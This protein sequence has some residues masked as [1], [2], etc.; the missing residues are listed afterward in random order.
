MSGC[1]PHYIFT[2]IL[3]TV[4]FAACNPV[5]ADPVVV[6]FDCGRWHLERADTVK[7][8]D[9]LSLMG[10]ASLDDVEFQDGI[11]HFSV[12]VSGKS[13]Y[14]GVFFRVQSA[15]NNERFYIRPHRAGLYPDALQYTPTINGIAGWQLYSGPGFTAPIELPVNEWIPV[16]LE[17]RG[18]QARV[19]I[20]EDTEP[21]LEIPYLQNGI[22]AGGITLDGP[23][24]GTAYLSDFSYELTDD[25]V[26]DAPPPRQI[27]VGT[28]LDWELS[29][30]FDLSGIDM[31]TY[32]PE[33]NLTDIKWERV[34]CDSTGLVDIARHR[35]PTGPAYVAFA[36]T[37][38]SADTAGLYNLQFGYSDAITI[39]LNGRRMFFGN[40]SYR[41][42]DP[43]FAGIIGT[44]DAVYLPL[45]KGDNE[46]MFFIAESFGGWGFMARD[47]D[48]VYMDERITP[49]WEI[50]QTMKYPESVAYD[51]VRNVI[52]VSNVANGGNE[53]L[54]RINPDGTVNQL[55]WITGLRA[56][57]G[58]HLHD[59]RLYAVTRTGVAVIDLN[60]DSLIAIHPIV[61]AVFP[62][63]LVVDGTGNIYV[64]D[65][66]GNVIH[67]V[68]EGGSEVWLEDPSIRDPNG[69]IIDGDDLIVGVSGDGTIKAVN[70]KDKSIRSIASIGISSVIDG[71][72]R[73]NDGSYL[74]S[75]YRGRLFQIKRNG[76]KVELLNTMTPEQTLADFV[77]IEGKH[78]VVIPTLFDNKIV[79]YEVKES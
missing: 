25:L 54:S 6:P 19:F 48:A 50:C 78:M 4:V 16:R 27:P 43:S 69:I 31:E 26:F 73:L 61:N 62:N 34:I 67:R 66:S 70:M 65:S 23:R 9:R 74:V 11:I 12:A 46:L 36:R 42:R 40:S 53:F 14:P 39:F 52:Y 30:A 1:R 44:N 24:N 49:L 75:D 37:I 8:L 28:I 63:D 15:L 56:P 32:L 76:V 68:W 3:C 20:G 57:T 79:A 21:A 41:S 64:T 38:L 59:D 45:E 18:T 22:S 29:P 77:Y 72:Q 51:P 55:M 7:H 33:Q 10:T 35:T 47:G 5:P 60:A 2:T 13:S 17:V 71:I 58:L